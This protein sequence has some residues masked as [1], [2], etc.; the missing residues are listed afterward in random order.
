[1]GLIKEVYGYGETWAM[2]HGKGLDPIQS[3]AHNNQQ[4]QAGQGADC[5]AALGILTAGD[6]KRGRLIAGTLR[7]T[8]TARLRLGEGSRPQSEPEEH[9]HVQD[10]AAMRHRWSSYRQHV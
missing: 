5:L 7:W 4:R 2:D 10:T 6:T 8:G 3:E 1:M 9:G